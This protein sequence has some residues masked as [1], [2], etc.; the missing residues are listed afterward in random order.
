M[1]DDD[2]HGPPRGDDG[3]EP[4]GVESDAHPDPEGDTPR[5]V[6][7]IGASAGGLAALRALLTRFEPDTGLAFVVVVHLSPEYESHLDSLLQPHVAMP[8]VQ[9]TE[10][11]PLVRDRIY[12]IPPGV[13][14]NTIDSHLRLTPLEAAR[15]ERAPIDHF[16]R[17]LAGT[18]GGRAIAVVLTGTGS[19]GTLGIKRIKERG[20]LAI[21]QDPNE[22]EFDGMPQSAISTGVVDRVLTLAEMPELI[23]SYAETRPRLR[24]VDD[25]EQLEADERAILLEIFAQ[26]RSLT[27]R[28]FSLYK[29][30]T[31]LR[32]IARRMQ[33]HRVEQLGDYLALL[34]GDASEVEALADEFLINVTHFFRDEAVFERFEDDVVP[35]IC[36]DRRSSE[37]VRVWSV[38]CATG[39][40]AYSLA[41][42]LLEVAGRQ[43]EAP[44]VQVFA[45]DLHAHSLRRAREGFYPLTIAGDVRPDR[46]Q[47]FFV[48]EEDGYRI[49]KQVREVVVFAPHDL[50]SDPPFSK[51]DL[52]SCRNVM[53]YL[54]RA[55]QRDVLELFHYSLS[56]DGFLVLGTS[57]SID[58]PDLFAP[59][60][61]A[62]C[63]YRRRAAPCR[64]PQ[65]PVFPVVHPRR[66][67]SPEPRAA[68][69]EPATY[70]ALHRQIVERYAPPS[71]LVDDEFNVVHLSADAGRYFT[72]PAG[73]I[74]HQVFRLVREPLR[75]ELRAA[76]HGARERGEA[77]RSEPIVTEVDGEARRIGLRVLPAIEQGR[78]GFILVVFDDLGPALGEPSSVPVGDGGVEEEREA[79]ATLLKERLQ[80]LIEEYE[81]TK[82]EMKAGNEELQSTNE[83]LR[84]TMEELETSKEEL[85]SMNEELATLNQENRH[86]VEE[87]SQLSSDLQNLWTATDIATLFLDRQL[88]ILR[89]T[90]QIGRLFNMRAA[91]RGRP[92]SDLT[93]RLGYAGLLGDAQGVLER[94]VPVEREVEDH[95]GRWYLARLLPYRSPD[96]RIEGVV[97]TFVDITTRRSA[98]A[99]LVESRLALAAELELSRALSAVMTRAVAAESMHAAAELILGA[100]VELDEADFG[101]L[102]LLDEGGAIVLTARCGFDEA[103][104]AA[105]AAAECAALPCRRVIDA[106]ERLSIGDI[107]RDPQSAAFRETARAIGVRAL[108]AAPLMRRGA[109]ICGVICLGFREPVAPSSRSRRMLDLVARQAADVIERLRAEARLRQAMVTLEE[110]VAERTAALEASE[111]RFR[112]LVDASS[113]TVWTTDADGIVVDDSP[114]WRAFTGQTF[115][116][117]RGEGWL[118]AVHPDDRTRA[119][120]EWRAAIARGDALELEYRLQHREGGWRW[121]QV[122]AVPLHDADGQRTGWVGMN[123]D[124]DQ[125]KQAERDRQLLMR[126]LTMAE[127]S[128]RRRISQV[129]HDDLQQVLYGIEIKVKMMCE[130]EAAK[131]EAETLA[132]CEDVRAW[133]TQAIKT[134]RQ[135][136]VSLSPP[137]LKA[138]GLFEA[139][140]WLRSQMAELHAFTVELESVG[141]LPRLDEDVRVLVFH[142]VRELL[143]N[144]IKHAE[145]D[146]ATV[147]LATTDDEVTVTVA[148]DGLG[149]D[150]EALVQSGRRGEQFGL[151]SIEER[152]RLIGGRL[153]IESVVGDG[154]RIVMHAPRHP[155]RPR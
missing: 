86:K 116:E 34:R 56:P 110:R 154:T 21:V 63:I 2:G 25:P 84:S 4:R 71:V 152:L 41:M 104:A 128:E 122:R 18:H 53:I 77:T 108:H 31:L 137:I 59:Y 40:E 50:L 55:T 147:T 6:V 133:I 26:V 3:G 98:E 155:Q 102:H 153:D 94:L 120:A 43:P 80:A 17:T 92:L 151:Y 139:L 79:E 8:V 74:T 146:H 117:W 61:K 145:V 83:E 66:P 134:T 78:R 12:V 38:G 1:S 144:A 130:R 73:Q 141:A 44:Q 127:Q 9:V 91:D 113:Q 46:L 36:A 111:R 132:E 101:T 70:D 126:E 150:A 112:A 14:L 90:P 135:L 69:R 119:R 49:T 96:D 10:T 95:E 35:Q 28:D 106:K 72:L 24:L 23:I 76:L 105:L 37:T 58:R 81:T 129:L 75:I 138:E 33:L 48:R 82:E 62:H 109:E 30:S 142:A 87:L 149:F 136:T 60:D 67:E 140:G 54:Q 125:R 27:G 124:V 47:R 45:S 123:I 89:F 64:E 52:V 93:H 29:R 57:E 121:T 65:L 5:L 97:L 85:Q 39:E 88:R 103:A 19:D 131:L 42:V 32:R 143:F 7:G 118:S 15:R 20:G 11:Q 51:L 13:N 148:D 22:A 107:E 115:D 99:A 68:W 100:A 114:S 16:F